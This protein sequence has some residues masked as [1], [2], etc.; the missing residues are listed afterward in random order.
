MYNLI[1][2]SK[3]VLEKVSPFDYEKE[4]QAYFL[5]LAM[6]QILESLNRITVTSDNYVEI[7][8]SF[9]TL[10]GDAKRAFIRPHV[11]YIL[12]RLFQLVDKPFEENQ[13]Y[14]YFESLDNVGIMCTDTIAEYTVKMPQTFFE[15]FNIDDFMTCSRRLLDQHSD[16][17]KTSSAEFASKK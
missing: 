16:K 7:Y 6:A 5:G 4:E 1:S 17:Q 8:F 15:R 14:A 12:A 2:T 13:E 3:V 10:L 9:Y 11:W